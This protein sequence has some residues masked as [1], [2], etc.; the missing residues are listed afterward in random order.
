[1][2]RSKAVK[3]AGATA[4]TLLAGAAGI[5][6]N[7]GIAGSESPGD[8]GNIKPVDATR[9]PVTVYVDKFASTTS[10]AVVPFAPIVEPSEREADSRSAASAT[11]RSD[12]DDKKSD[13]HDDDH[14]DKKSDDHH[15]DHDKKS[16]KHYEGADDDD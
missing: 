1:M 10:T 5:A 4:L 9:V 11:G 2:E 14:D 8:V 16:D 12:D 6:I 7:S 3:V 15:D 13:D